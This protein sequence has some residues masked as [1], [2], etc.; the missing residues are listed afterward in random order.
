MNYENNDDE[1]WIHEEL[2]RLEHDFRKARQPYI[3]ML[4]RIES[5][6]PSK[7]IVLS[8]EQWEIIN[9]TNNP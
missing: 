6:K 9:Q 2:L 8:K 7:P 5:L 1:K 3:D 4:V